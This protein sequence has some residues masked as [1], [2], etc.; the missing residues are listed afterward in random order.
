MNRGARAFW[1]VV[2]TM[3][4]VVAGASLGTTMHQLV[5]RHDAALRTPGL[6]YE[7]EHT[8]KF[9]FCAQTGKPDQ[10][11]LALGITI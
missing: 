1:S 4:I 7:L 3:L 2:A 5:E 8:R 10:C 9:E 11:A 6:Q